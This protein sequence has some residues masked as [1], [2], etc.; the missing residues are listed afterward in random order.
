MS[1]ILNIHV[2][3][4]HI[5]GEQMKS[6]FKEIIENSA[7]VRGTQAKITMIQTN[8]ASNKKFLKFMEGRDFRLIPLISSLKKRPG[9]GS[10]L[11]S[12][13]SVC[14]SLIKVLKK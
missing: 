8:L 10:R 7:N 9:Y 12:Y 6:D 2:H 14:E 11:M 1:M 13:V 3:L 4:T 5:V